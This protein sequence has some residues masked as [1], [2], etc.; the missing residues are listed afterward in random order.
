MGEALGPRTRYGS[1]GGVL[2]PEGPLRRLQ[3]S[4]G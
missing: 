4:L 2:V 1:A 3:L